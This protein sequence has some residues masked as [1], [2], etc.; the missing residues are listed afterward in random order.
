MKFTEKHIRQLAENGKIKSFHIPERTKGF[1]SDKS[2]HQFSRTRSKALDWLNWNLLFWAN[3]NAL[4]I[5]SSGNGGELV[6]DP[7]RKWR[8]DFCFPAVKIA[9]EYEGGIFMDNSGHNTA[10]HYTK[11]TEKYNRAAVLGWRVIRVTALN[12]TTVLKQLNE[13]INT[14]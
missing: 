7:Q 4:Q 12:Y 1:S 3:D 5:R 13:L 2:P 11:D 8:F 6:F 14:I 9:V 10:K